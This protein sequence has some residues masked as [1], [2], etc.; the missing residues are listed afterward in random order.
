MSTSGLYMRVHTCTDTLVPVPC[1]HTHVNTHTL[2]AHTY[3]QPQLRSMPLVDIA[4]FLLVCNSLLVSPKHITLSPY[5]LVL[6]VVSFILVS[7]FDFS[8]HF[9]VL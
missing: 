1:I 2:T 5:C 4:S 6:D 9:S 3:T 8:L 7:L